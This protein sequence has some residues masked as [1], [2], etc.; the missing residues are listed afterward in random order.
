MTT[1]EYPESWGSN[2]AVL[3]ALAVGLVMELVLVGLLI[4]NEVVG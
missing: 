4:G 1:E 3:G 2:V